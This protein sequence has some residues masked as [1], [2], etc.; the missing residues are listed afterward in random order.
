MYSHVCKGSSKV[1]LLYTSACVYAHICVGG[2]VGRCLCCGVATCT[3]YIRH[4]V[5]E[6]SRTLYIQDMTVTAYIEN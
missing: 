1:N 4:V 3:V 5:D 6:D 2:R